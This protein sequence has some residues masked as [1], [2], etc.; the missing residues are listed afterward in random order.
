MT[1]AKHFSLLVATFLILVSSV[2]AQIS[3]FSIGI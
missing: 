1:R 3:I 2:A